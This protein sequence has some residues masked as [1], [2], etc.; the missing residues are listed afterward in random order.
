MGLLAAV[1]Q[2]YKR[3]HAAEQRMWLGWM[4]NIEKRLKPLPSTSFEYLEPAD[5]SNRATRLRVR[6]DGNALGFTGTELV[7]KLD[8]GTPRIL[9]DGGTGRRP[10]QMASSVIIM[11]YMMDPGE[12]RIIADAMYAA[13]TKPGHYP[14]P[15]VPSG[16]PAAVEGAWAVSVEYLCGQGSQK[17]TLRQD[18]GDVS[19]MHQGEIYNGRLRGTVRGDSV[20]F[21]TVMEVPGN[22]IRWTFTGT[23]QGGRMSGTAD[24]GEYGLARWTAVRA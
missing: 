24:M 5:L 16:A 13:M 17:F 6:W 3:D 20:E 10:D 12:D 15:P 19:G 14:D 9:I 23:H 8:A 1:E 4:Q 18:G 11:P 22:D 21:H 7:A 2:W